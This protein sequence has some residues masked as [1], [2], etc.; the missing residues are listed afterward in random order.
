MKTPATIVLLAA[1]L[2]VSAFALGLSAE[3]AE[4][5]ALKTY[6]KEDVERLCPKVEMGEGRIK[7]CLKANK[8]RM[9]VGC[10]QALKK[11]KDSKK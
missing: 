5:E 2:P 6:C 1:L 7:A 9:S 8:E 3:L 11:L 10:A 4:L